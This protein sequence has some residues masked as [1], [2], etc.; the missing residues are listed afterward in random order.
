MNKSLQEFIIKYLWWTYRPIKNKYKAIKT[1]QYRKHQAYRLDALIHD[2]IRLNL[3][4]VFYLGITE[5]PNLGDMAQHY[6]IT[7]WIKENYPQYDLQMFESS[8]VTD[9]RNNFIAKLKA[10]YKKNDIIIFQS[11]YCT[12]DLGGDHPLMH[13]I[14]ID[15]IPFA[16]IL[17]MPQTIFFKDEKNKKICA[18]N[19]NKAKNML[20]LARDSV[21]FEMAKVMFPDIHVMEFPDI[22][23]TLIGTL[24]FESSRQG[25]CICRRNDKEKFYSDEELRKLSLRFLSSDVF[26]KD[27]Q[28]N[29]PV[30]VIRN[31][32]WKFIYEEIESYSHYEVTITD[33]Y[34][35]TIF[36]LIAGTPVIILKTTDHKVISGDNWFKG[37][38]EEYVYLADNLEQA[39]NLTQEIRLNKKLSHQ[40]KPYMKTEYYDKLKT[41]FENIIR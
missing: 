7:K 29:A 23:T 25:I 10:V 15:A 40:L 14:V 37:L 38:Y 12:Q 3:P 8:V 41:Y 18:E 30:S 16:N 32:L 21:S 6:C 35:G 1:H 24:S 20:F 11:G 33:R 39:Y 31:N 4:R 34:H 36:S 19:H 17:M 13:R 9:S 27:T 28:G 26:F 5:Q 2:P 22:V